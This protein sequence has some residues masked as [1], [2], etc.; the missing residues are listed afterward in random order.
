MARLD[1][2]GFPRCCR[3]VRIG[4]D[5]EGVLTESVILYK[6]SVGVAHLD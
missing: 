2:L 3:F 6:H 1:V 4:S 5:I